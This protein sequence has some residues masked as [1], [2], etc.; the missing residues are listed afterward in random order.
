MTAP[1][2]YW[3]GQQFTA[4]WTLVDAAGTAVTDAT[5]AG[6]VTL[7][8]GGTAP[9]TVTTTDNIYTASYTAAA[10]GRHGWRITATGSHEDAVEGTFT[11]ARSLLGLPPITTDPSTSVGMVRLLITDLSE[12]APLFEDAQL[13]AL[14]TAE[15]G[16]VKRAAAAALETIARSEVL[17][18]KHTSTNDLSTNG[19]SVGAEL[20]A[21]AKSLR[22]QAKQDEDDLIGGNDA[23]G[24][25]VIDFDPQAAYRRW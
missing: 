6:V 12:T 1:H 23:W 9:M 2:T 18:A 20:R 10:P 16:S 24:I 17:I 11:V 15:R 21:S 5:V 25:S 4:V 22:D 13:S 19:P 3:Q 8:A 14:L 7:P